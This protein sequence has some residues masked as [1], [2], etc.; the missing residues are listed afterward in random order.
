MGLKT[1]L[2]RKR[3]GLPKVMKDE[4]LAAGVHIKDKKLPPV[5]D[6]NGKYIDLNVGDILPMQDLG[7]GKFAYYKITNYKRKS[8]GD[9]L[10]DTDAYNYDLE[11]SHIGEFRIRWNK[12]EE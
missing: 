12:I 11:F 4:W 8:G 1:K 3:Y 10:Y 9:W 6:A 7:N 2:L 5:W